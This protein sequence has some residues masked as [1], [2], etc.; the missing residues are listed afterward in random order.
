MYLYDV[1]RPTTLVQQ[2]PQA[3]MWSK[4]R[5][6]G[7]PTKAICL[8]MIVCGIAGTASG[9]AVDTRSRLRARA[10]L[11]AKVGVTSQTSAGMVVSLPRHHHWV[12]GKCGIR[13]FYFDNEVCPWKTASEVSIY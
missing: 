3:Q 12:Y 1:R 8:L 7:A 13:E 10:H 6:Q 9:A 5:K 11:A 2:L 4:E